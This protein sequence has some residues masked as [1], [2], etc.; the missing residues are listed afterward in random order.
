MVSI[1]YGYLP[2][3]VELASFA[4]FGADFGIGIGG[5]IMGVIA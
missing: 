5:A 4:G 3:I 1:I 2:G